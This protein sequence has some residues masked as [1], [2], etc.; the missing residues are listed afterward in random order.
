MSN[1]I[2][3]YKIEAGG[4][5]YEAIVWTASTTHVL[6]SIVNLANQ[7]WLELTIMRKW[8]GCT[9]IQ[10]IEDYPQLAEQYMAEN[11]LQYDDTYF[12]FC[13]WQE[14]KHRTKLVKLACHI[15]D[16]ELM[17]ADEGEG[18]R[19]KVEEYQPLPKGFT[20]ISKV[21]IDDRKSI[22]KGK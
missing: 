2:S 19:G 3:V 12:H 13:D 1:L 22:K 20:I 10:T 21:T 6:V 7:K 18:A 11:E 5:D 4:W 9:E 14:F 16:E 15:A 17:T 8:D